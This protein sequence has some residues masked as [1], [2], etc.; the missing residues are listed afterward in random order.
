MQFFH[1]YVKYRN[2]YYFPKQKKISGI[3]YLGILDDIKLETH[4]LEK[5]LIWIRE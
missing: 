3:S 4:N 1:I 2:K 5:I